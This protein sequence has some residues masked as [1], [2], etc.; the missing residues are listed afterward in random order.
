MADARVRLTRRGGI[1]NLDL[2][3]VRPSLQGGGGIVSSRGGPALFPMH[4]ADARSVGF[5]LAVFA[6]VR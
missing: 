6:I 4:R 1:A 2:V 3:S 5:F